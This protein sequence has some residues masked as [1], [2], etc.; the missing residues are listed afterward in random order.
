M[1]SHYEDIIGQ[2]RN[3]ANEKLNSVSS[4]HKEELELLQRSTEQVKEISWNFL[5]FERYKQKF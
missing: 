5:I 4:Q 3:E 1:T 2:L